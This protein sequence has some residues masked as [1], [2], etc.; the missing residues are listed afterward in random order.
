MLIA[1]M[2]ELA[3]NWQ[4]APPPC[5]SPTIAALRASLP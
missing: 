2:P 3:L 4:L 5:G 1:G